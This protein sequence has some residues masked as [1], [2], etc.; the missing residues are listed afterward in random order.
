ML[1]AVPVALQKK[2]LYYLHVAFVMNLMNCF[3]AASTPKNSPRNFGDVRP[4]VKLPRIVK[5]KEKN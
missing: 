2:N 5:E 3:F 4:V 1:N